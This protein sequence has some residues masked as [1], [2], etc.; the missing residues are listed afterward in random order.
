[1]VAAPFAG[2]QAGGTLLLVSSRRR[3]C[4]FA[5]A[6]AAARPSACFVQTGN[7]GVGLGSS[8]PSLQRQ[9]GS[10]AGT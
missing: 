1:M 6:P 7:A 3:V 5:Q 4:G 9:Q 8:I 10:K 2:P